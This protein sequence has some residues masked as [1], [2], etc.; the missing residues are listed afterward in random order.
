MS[1]ARIRRCHDLTAVSRLIGHDRRYAMAMRRLRA[2]KT[3][4]QHFVLSA[5]ATAALAIDEAGLEWPSD[6]PLRL[7]LLDTNTHEYLDGGQ[8]YRFLAPMLGNDRDIEVYAFGHDPADARSSRTAGILNTK[9]NIRTRATLQSFA[10]Y[11]S[12]TDRITGRRPDLDIDL[13]MSFSGFTVIPTLLADLVALRQRQVPLYVTSFSSTH[14]LLNHAVLRAHRAN[15][16][17]VLASNPF[18]LVSKRI[19]E[20]WNRVISKVPVEELPTADATIDDDY[21]DKLTVTASMVLNSHKLGD[22]SQTWEVGGVIDD[23][24]VHTLDG[25]AVDTRTYFVVDAEDREPLGQ[26]RQDFHDVISD[27]DP[28]WDETD[29]L[30]WAAHIRYFAMAEGFTDAPDAQER[31]A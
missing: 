11:F 31:R 17:P 22:P 27:F 9:Y 10:D 16:T 20:N 15:A 19:G 23:D 28:S 2:T 29:R 13:A 18:G 24:L 7:A 25:I 14:A 30:I 8:W 5:P 26:F 12:T 4:E 3:H 6:R 1:L 21:M